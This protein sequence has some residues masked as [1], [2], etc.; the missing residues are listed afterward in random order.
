MDP[1][2]W[3]KIQSTF[4]TIVE[5][6]S[7]DRQNRLAALSSSDPEVH[8]AVKSLLAADSDA[9]TRLA[10]LDAVFLQQ[11]VP[12]ADLLGLAGQTISHFQIREPIG[13]GGMGVVYR[14]EDTRLGRAV[15]LKFLLPSH[16]LD[17]SAKAR[18]LREAHMVAA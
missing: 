8:A 5:M 13:T 18:F 12:P 2:R 14:A 7:A 11:V 16:S 1:R 15:A 17:S 4:D 10:A 6:D 3:Q 9:D